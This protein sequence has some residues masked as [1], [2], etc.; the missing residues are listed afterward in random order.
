[1]KTGPPALSGIVVQNAGSFGSGDVHTYGE[2]DGEGDGSLGLSSSRVLR[3]S[4]VPERSSWLVERVVLVQVGPVG[5]VEHLDARGAGRR[6]P[7]YT[8]RHAD[9]PG[10]AVAVG[11]L[12]H[13]VQPGVVPDAAATLPLGSGHLGELIGGGDPAAVVGG[14]RG[15]A[16]R[17]REYSD[18]L[19]DRA[20]EPALGGAAPNPATTWACCRVRG[21]DLVEGQQRVLDGA[22]RSPRRPSSRRGT[23]SGCAH[24][25]EHHLVPLAVVDRDGG[26]ERGMPPPNWPR[27]RPSVPT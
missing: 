2:G 11:V 5:R 7:P 27:S 16:E 10:A 19:V 24:R 4:G 3:P 6:V 14:D 25:G 22:L 23:G 12:A 17:V 15:R 21:A 9:L 20:G 26:G 13:P 8:G 1:M 18:D